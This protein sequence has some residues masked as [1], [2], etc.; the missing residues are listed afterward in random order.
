M[1]KK[2]KQDRSFVRTFFI[3]YPKEDNPGFESARAWFIS[4]RK[5]EKGVSF[6]VGLILKSIKRL[7]TN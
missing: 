4:S 3:R 7:F 2:T 1:K 6:M 5:S